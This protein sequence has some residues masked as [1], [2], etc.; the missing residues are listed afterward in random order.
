[1]ER[2]VADGAVVAERDEPAALGGDGAADELGGMAR[3]AVGCRAGQPGPVEIEQKP[4]RAVLLILACGAFLWI[5]V[6]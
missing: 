4:R 1:M 2:V 6:V 3:V 5:D